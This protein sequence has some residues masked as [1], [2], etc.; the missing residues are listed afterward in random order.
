M[1]YKTIVFELLAER[2]Q[3]H[4]HL[5]LSRRLLPTLEWMAAE[6]RDRHMDWTQALAQSRP[7]ST[8][9]QLAAE[10]MELAL[11]DLEFPATIDEA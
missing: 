9:E 11:R 1:L 7:D 4:E 6:L 8:P 2:P 10:A 5:R 3:L